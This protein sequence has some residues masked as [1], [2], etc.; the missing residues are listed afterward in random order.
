MKMAEI[1]RRTQKAQRWDTFCDI[2]QGFGM[3]FLILLL[4]G[5][6]RPYF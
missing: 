1:H 2:M 5:W 3:A 4:C 6:F